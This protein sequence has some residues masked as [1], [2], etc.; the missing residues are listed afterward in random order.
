MSQI[1]TARHAPTPRNALHW[2]IR[3]GNGSPGIEFLSIY[4]NLDYGRSTHQTIWSSVRICS[5]TNR[6][7]RK[8]E[9]MFVAV[10]F[11][12]DA[13]SRSAMGIRLPVKLIR[14]EN[15]NWVKVRGRWNVL[16]AVRKKCQF[17]FSIHR[18]H[19]VKREWRATC[20]V[21]TYKTLLFFS[22]P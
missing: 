20:T 3:S 8:C 4:L 14:T 9:R 5:R 11:Y 16:S 15:E 6:K 17:R 12:G 13:G 19:R 1:L 18:P 10:V 21:L 2:K 7:I 22:C